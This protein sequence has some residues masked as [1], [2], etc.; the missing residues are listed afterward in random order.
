M[1]THNIHIVASNTSTGI[2][3]FDP[4]QSVHTRVRA[5]DTVKWHIRNGSGVDAILN[6][7]GKGGSNEMWSQIPRQQGNH[8]E[9][10]VSATAAESDYYVYLITWRRG[11]N[12][13][14]H[15]P[16]ISI[17]PSTLS[18]VVDFVLK[19]CAG[20]VVGAVASFLYWRKMRME[21]K[22]E[23]ELLRKESERLKTNQK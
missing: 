5:G 19:V 18:H 9:G 1:P 10:V 6:I 15:D 11:S 21:L 22:R 12:N 8:W 7:T 20:L 2:L 13:Y 16:L 4:P 23:N 3:T 17:R 14:T